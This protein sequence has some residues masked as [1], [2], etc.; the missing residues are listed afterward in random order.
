MFFENGI[1][2]ATSGGM[3]KRDEDSV[4]GMKILEDNQMDNFED[5]QRELFNSK[6]DLGT[7]YEKYIQVSQ[8]T[9]NRDVSKIKIS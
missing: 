1:R 6:D 7:R 5:S 3:G 8:K 2:D 4:G 9:S